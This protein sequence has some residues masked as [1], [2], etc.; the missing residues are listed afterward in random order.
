[1]RTPILA[2][3]AALALAAGTALAAGAA[4]PYSV[5]ELVAKHIEARGGAEKLKGIKSVRIEGL[6]VN[7]G[8]GFELAT[9]LLASRPDAVRTEL[10][11][12]GLTII[13]AYDGKE[14]WAV[15]PFRGRK[16]PE[17]LSADLAKEMAYQ[18]DFDGPLVDYKAKGNKVDYL[19][20]EDV[21]GTEA[22]KLKVTRANGDV[23]T[24][25][26]DPDYFLQIRVLEQHRIRGTEV[27]Q[28]SDFGDYEQVDGVYFP[29]SI[30]SGGKGETEKGQKFTVNKVELNVPADEGQ[31]R[32]PTAAAPAK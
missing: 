4:K 9:V 17:K 23:D 19:G 16:D 11:L 8:Q 28:E 15:N 32:F 30:E 24:I 10:T 14:G 12:Q 1:M 20:I 21:D 29:F 6:T 13:R 7:A 18:A 25:W 26:L 27:E 31:F 3:C 5:D 22:H 2:L